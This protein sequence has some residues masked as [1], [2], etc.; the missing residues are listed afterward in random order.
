MKGQRL[1]TGITTGMLVSLLSACGALSNI[2]LPGNEHVA[3]TPSVQDSC[4][5]AGD[6]PDFKEGNCLLDEWVAF[7]LQA[8]RG[9]GQW[10]DS[11]LMQLEG[12]RHDRRLARAIVL[13][14]GDESDW[15]LA[16]DLYKADLPTAPSRLQPLLRQWLNGLEERRGLIA[17]R[18]K[19]EGVRR[20]LSAENAQLSK[21]L[22]ALTAIEEAINSRRQTTP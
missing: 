4:H 9:N 10:R 15:E 3:D 5:G 14:W 2:T 21:K 18:D 20:K 6:L 17:D 11:T 12:N 8:Q 16:S 19:S 1:L 13:S 7:A 22:E